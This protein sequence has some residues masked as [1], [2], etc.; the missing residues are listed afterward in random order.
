V[1]RNEVSETLPSLHVE[2]LQDRLVL[3]FALQS[4]FYIANVSDTAN[5]LAMGWPRPSCRL[6]LTR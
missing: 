1:L 3:A 4:G 6:G 2:G 5:A